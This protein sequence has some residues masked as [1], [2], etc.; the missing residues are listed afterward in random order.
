MDETVQRFRHDNEARGI[1]HTAGNSSLLSVTH[2][3]KSTAPV[4]FP[5]RTEGSFH[6]PT[7]RQSII[8]GLENSLPARRKLIHSSGT[9]GNGRTHA[10]LSDMATDSADAELGIAHNRPSSERIRMTRLVS[11]NGTDEEA[12]LDVFENL[13][14]DENPNRRNSK[15]TNP[16]DRLR[17]SD[18]PFTDH[19]RLGK[20][21]RR[22]A[23]LKSIGDVV[24]QVGRRVVDLRT[25]DDDHE[26]AQPL[27]L[28]DRMDVDGEVWDPLND[29][30]DDGSTGPIGHASWMG[31]EQADSPGRQV[32]SA[33]VPQAASLGDKV[34]LGIADAG[35]SQIPLR[36][37][38]LGVFG[39]RNKFRLALYHTLKRPYVRTSTV[40]SLGLISLTVVSFKT[41]SY[42]ESCVLVLLV[43]HVG[44]LLSQSASTL[45]APRIDDG[46][47]DSW[48]DT[49]LLV[50]F[51]LYTLEA[52]A[53]IITTG[54]IF[55]PKMT[56][57]IISG[58]SESRKVSQP[59]LYFEGLVWLWRG[60][61]QHKHEEKSAVAG[62]Q[63]NTSA[64]HPSSLIK[65]QIRAQQTWRA[66][67]T[68]EPIDQLIKEDTGR[69]AGRAN[70][71][72]R[73]KIV[74]EVPFEAALRR[75]IRI[76]VSGRPYL[77]HSW[78]YVLSA[79]SH[80]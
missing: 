19:G 51:V 20:S 53:R 54:L 32:G 33:G 42:T 59:R 22:S 50:I 72:R 69:L 49:A 44:V 4:T 41:C 64:V 78:Q 18:I 26:E 52:L 23:T 62:L 65:R 58:S 15:L 17:F 60:K 24:R 46:Y 9:N 36:G 61:T 80:L 77:R 74:D 67:H 7:T 12:D 11:Q 73:R 56:V 79:F 2:A 8:N 68:S 37:H 35:L 29:S 27:R 5:S 6:Q 16:Q 25:V 55:D 1:S 75:Q 43:V 57:P 13:V 70:H 14:S 63:R 28:P 38:S 34:P 21:L 48:E 39:P 10:L 40:E 76:V 30:D 47:F 71:T 31:T 3:R 66:D 45:E